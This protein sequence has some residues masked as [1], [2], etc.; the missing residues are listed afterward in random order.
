MNQLGTPLIISQQDEVKHY[1]ER[2]SFHPMLDRFRDADKQQAAMLSA[3]SDQVTLSIAVLG[4]EI[5][6]YAIVL[7]PEKEERWSCYDYI[8]VLGVVE[9]AP[10]YRGNG[11]AKKLVKSVTSPDIIEKQII[12]SIEYYWHWD[13]EM[14]DGDPHRYVLI[15]KKM[16]QSAGFEEF[17]TNDPDIAGYPYNFMMG[18]VG[19]EVT[20]EQLY[21]F[22]KL[23]HPNA[24]P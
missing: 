6:G 23:A 19:K 4:T 16:L 2:S 14:T 20:Q 17:E 9:I 8:K 15:L 5:V 11:L 10:P 7:P 1:M 22:V 18:R 21:E 24:L 3:L 13:L 12:V